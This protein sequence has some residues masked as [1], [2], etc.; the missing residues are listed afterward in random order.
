[1]VRESIERG[2]IM[3][4][5]LLVPAQ[6]LGFQA[7]TSDHHGCM[8]ILRV[9]LQAFLLSNDFIASMLLIC[10][11]LKVLLLILREKGLFFY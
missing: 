2:G 11:G 9:I 7:P 10:W 4:L 5:A 1:M 6:A 3:P 8:A